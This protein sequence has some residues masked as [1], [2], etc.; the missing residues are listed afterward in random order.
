MMK[1]IKKGLFIVIDGPDGSGIST[2]VEL[3]GKWLKELGKKVITTKEPTS[4]IIGGIIR[5]VLKH[6]WETD[7]MTLQL[8]FSA[9]RA[10]HLKKE[11][12]PALKKGYIVISDRYILSTYCF[13]TI[14]G[15]NLD[16]LRSVNS[17]FVKPNL[18]IIL[19]V[20]PEVSVV[21]IK[22]SRAS[23]ELFEDVKK[24][25]RIREN[26]KRL[27]KEFPNTFVIDATKSIEEVHEEIKGIVRKFL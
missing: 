7:Q 13:G 18:T 11:I 9:D 22:R 12:I 25:R 15:V 14:D 16:W 2:Q 8:L 10:H 26:F 27:S 24:L 19:D 21:R 6:E 1:K 23:I 3:L 5:A 17:Q 4:G 20:P